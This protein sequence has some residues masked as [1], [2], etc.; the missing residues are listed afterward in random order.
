M[1]A[2]FDHSW[3]LLNPGERS[4]LRQLAVFHGGCTA[5]AAAAVAGAALP[6]LADLVDKS[7]LRTRTAGR[8]DMH[9][10]V[11]QYCTEKLDQEHA[12][13]AGE[14]ADAVRQR[15]SRYYGA[16]ALE[17]QQQHAWRPEAAAA[18]TADFANLES[19]WQWMVEH[20]DLALA[21]QL[22]FGF[23]A[24][25]EL[26]GWH[27]MLLPSS[28]TRGTTG[29]GWARVRDATPPCADL[30]LR[31]A[32]RLLDAAV[33]RPAEPHPTGSSPPSSSST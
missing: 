30:D 32:P 26:A 6:D 17:Q 28:T 1:R 22:L 7:W 4:I 16:W 15:H 3:R 8:Y 14:T 24:A 18:L 10:L 20:E 29:I 25:V 31:D 13:A 11:R 19:A 33:G 12:T 27:R 9:E 2:V 5:D 21:R 23:T